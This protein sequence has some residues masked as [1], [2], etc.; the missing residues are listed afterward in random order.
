MPIGSDSV[1]SGLNVNYTDAVIHSFRKGIISDADLFFGR[2]KASPDY[3]IGLKISDLTK[4][5]FVCG[6]PGSGKTS[7]CVGLLDRLWRD[8]KIPFLVIEPAKT[9]YR[10][11]IETIPDLQVFTPGNDF[12]SPFIFNPFIPPKNVKLGPYKTV[13]KTAFEAGVSMSSPLDMI[14]ERSINNCYSDHLWLDYYD[15][16]SGADIFDINEFMHCFRKTFRSIGYVGEASNIGRAGEIRLESISRMFDGY[17]SIPIEDMLSKPTVIELAA[18][19]NPQQKALLIS[20]ILLSIL[21]YV[22]ENFKNDGVLKNVLLL[23]EAHILLDADSENSSKDANS[24]AIAQSLVKKILAEL[25]SFGLGMVV[26]DQSPRRVGLDILALTDIKTVFRVVENRDRDLIS[27][28][29]GLDE[30]S[31]LSKFRP[32]EAYLFFNKMDMPEEIIVDEYRDA[33]NIPT[34]LSNDC[35]LKKMKYWDTHS[36]LLKP[37]PECNFLQEC[38]STCDYKRRVAAKGI[39]RRLCSKYL[40]SKNKKEL[41]SKFK[42]LLRSLP[43]YVKLEIGLEKYSVELVAC[44]KVHLVRDAKYVY[45]LKISKEVVEHFVKIT[46][47]D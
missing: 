37:Y 32:G 30:C 3:K 16:G 44:V 36:I 4:H 43:D 10:A 22:N 29:I 19:E 35:L 2:L 46:Y 21:S 6:T 18:I 26:C 20:I 23:E 34:H 1:R 8:H 42:Q 7:F 9:E 5:M 12:V 31:R 39:T 47:P 25:R 33:N 14:F 41:I 38:A 27:G 28:S 15:I 45:D 13:L 17:S 40:I 24:V 11:L